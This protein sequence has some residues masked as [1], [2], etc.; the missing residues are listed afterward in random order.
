MNKTDSKDAMTPSQLITDQ[1][2]QLTDWRGIMLARLRELILEAAPGITEGWKWGSSVWS[3][4]GNVVSVA[5][6]KDHVRMT[7]FKG[8]ALEDPQGL[9][10]AGH[11]A[12]VLRSINFSEGD[13]IREAALLALIRAAV[14]L[15][16]KK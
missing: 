4:K 11:D 16:L 8:A 12:K 5:A 13:K 6:F 14:V 10:N 2:T 15:D 7:F 3:Q 9:F 1:I